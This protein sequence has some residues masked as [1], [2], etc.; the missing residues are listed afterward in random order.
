[1]PIYEYECL[2]CGGVSEFIEGVSAAPSEKV[3]RHCGGEALRRILPQGV[4]SRM[5]G[6]IGRRAG[7]TCCGRQERCGSPPCDD[8]GGCCR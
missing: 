4:T 7:A 3:C 8:V 1:M 5:E 2:K 6:V